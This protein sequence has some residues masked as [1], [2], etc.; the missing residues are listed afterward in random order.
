MCFQNT[1]D[2]FGYRSIDNSRL[3]RLNFY[4]LALPGNVRVVALLKGQITFSSGK[5]R[6]IDIS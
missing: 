1:Y 4:S 6:V 5:I 3:A 2:L